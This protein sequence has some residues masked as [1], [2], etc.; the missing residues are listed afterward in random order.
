MNEEIKKYID[1][2]RAR[3]VSD[4][5]MRSELLSKGWKEGDVNICLGVIVSSAAPVAPM[6]KV[7]RIGR[8]RYFL[9]PLCT[10]GPLFALVAV[11][12]VIGYMQVQ[13]GMGGTP[14]SNPFFAMVNFAI[15][16]LLIPAVLLALVGLYLSIMLGIR[17][18]H[19]VGQSGWFLLLTLIPYIGFIFGLYLLFKKGDPSANKYGQPSPSDRKFFADIFNY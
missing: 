4:A 13:A 10:M 3:G 7:A 11:W 8:L 16:L 5:A 19:D 17:R 12:G 2:E 18:T 15:P 6:G 14:A 1:G 9:G